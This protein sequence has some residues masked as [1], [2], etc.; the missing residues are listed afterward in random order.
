MEPFWIRYRSPD[1]KTI[2][3]LLW[4]FVY[5]IFFVFEMFYMK[6]MYYICSCV[7]FFNEEFTILWY[8]DC[9]L[10]KWTIADELYYDVS[11]S[12]FQ[13]LGNSSCVEMAHLDNLALVITSQGT[14]LLKWHTLMQGILRSLLL[15]CAILLYYWKVSKTMG[16]VVAVKINYVVLF[17]KLHVHRPQQCTFLPSRNTHSAISISSNPW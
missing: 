6:F 12:Y 2:H 3:F 10:E 4:S 11:S 15:V 8:Y 1:S 17:K 14:F 9:L 13:I 16:L 7:R 5:R